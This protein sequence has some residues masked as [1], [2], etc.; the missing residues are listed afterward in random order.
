MPLASNATLHLL[1]EAG[2]RDER[3]LGAVRCKRFI[4][5]ESCFQCYCPHLAGSCQRKQ[6][7]APVEDEYARLST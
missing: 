5:I 4:G 6:A 2:A 3:R 7:Q 1:P